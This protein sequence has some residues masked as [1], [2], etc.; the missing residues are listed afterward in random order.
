MQKDIGSTNIK[1]QYFMLLSH[2]P[3]ILN[4]FNNRVEHYT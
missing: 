4:I 1:K 2:D 3:D